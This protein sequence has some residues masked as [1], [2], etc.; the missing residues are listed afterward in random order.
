MLKIFIFAAGV[1][2]W[3]SVADLKWNVRLWGYSIS[4]VV[5]LTQDFLKQLDKPA[6]EKGP[7]SD[8]GAI[9]KP[10]GR[11]SNVLPLD[12]LSPMVADGVALQGICNTTRGLF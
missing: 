5:K 7:Q 8:L 4:S 6:P 9:A 10:G 2:E 12:Q 11:Q 1:I 3:V